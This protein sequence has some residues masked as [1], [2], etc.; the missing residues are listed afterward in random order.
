MSIIFNTI[1]QLV[2]GKIGRRSNMKIL[3]S[4]YLSSRRDIE[5]EISDTLSIPFVEFITKFIGD[6]LS[7]GEVV[8]GSYDLLIQLLRNQN[9]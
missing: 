7:K 3:K 8:P 5:A 9:D 1:R 4:P 2:S 6:L